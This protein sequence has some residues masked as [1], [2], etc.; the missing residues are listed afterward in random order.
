V[1]A[2][3]AVAA[4]SLVWL[5]RAL[6]R[7]DRFRASVLGGPARVA[8]SVLAA[9]NAASA[10]KAA[11]SFVGGPTVLATSGES[12]L[13]LAEGNGVKI[14]AGCRMGM[15]GA[16]PV[17]ILDGEEHLSPCMG[18]ERATLERLDAGAGCRM[19]C[20]AKVNGP[21]T[22]LPT[23]DPDAIP[24]GYSRSGAE[25]ESVGPGFE[26]DQSVRRVIVI[27]NGVAGTTAA[28]EVRKLHPDATVTLFGRESYD[29][30]NRMAIGHLV[31][32]KSGISNLYL[33]GR[34]WHTS[35]GVLYHPD[36]RV[37]HVDPDAH[38][39]TTED[40]EALPYD[41][42][43][44]ATGSDSMVPPLEGFGTEG[45]FVLR[46]INDA[47][48][49]QQHVRRNRCRTAVIVG[50]G[51]LGLEAAYD[52]SEIG[53]RCYVLNRGGWPLDRQLDAAAGGL[54]SQLMADLGI[55]VLA[56]TSAVRILGDDRVN[57]VELT[58]G[59]T[60]N[61]DLVLVTAGIQPIIDLAERGGLEV[62]R[63]IVVDDRMQTSHPDIYAAGD[64]A[65]LGGRTFGLWPAGMEQGKIAATNLLGGDSHY[66]PT[67]PPARLKVAGIDLLSV[68]LITTP[69]D[70]SE[71]VAKEPSSR[72]YRKLI[73]RGD[74]LVGAI[75]IGYAELF[76][77]VSDAVTASADVGAYREQLAAGDWSMIGAPVPAVV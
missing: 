71:I 40:G 15:C 62:N 36:R 8:D 11:V 13:T 73:L 39:V 70:G 23:I 2:E 22:V 57:G 44:L 9:A 58:T 43:L 68:G 3:V 52:L 64:C 72:T 76:D 25:A 17:R 51:L 31:S 38:L 54:L 14:E 28:T 49:I 41:R 33:L 77:P 7:E 45:S 24:E 66:Q 53:V 4:L 46:T 42:L 34:D 16:D 6:P 61:A 59:T 35:K 47:V 74:T 69:E 75:I 63:G 55:T 18:A 27:G 60:L 12:L 67:V 10:V 56:R 20:M 1:P 37:V 30:Y 50:G 48:Q 32:E 5:V 29:F 65:S 26:I 19:A 21:V